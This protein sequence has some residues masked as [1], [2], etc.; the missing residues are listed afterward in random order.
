MTAT[1]RHDAMDSEEHFNIAKSHS[2]QKQEAVSPKRKSRTG[3]ADS[4]TKEKREA[5]KRVRSNKKVVSSPK[6]D[7]SPVAT[8]AVEEVFES[9]RR[10]KRS[11]V[12]S[13]KTK[14]EREELK[15]VRTSQEFTWSRNLGNADSKTK[16]KREAPKRVRSNKKVVISPKEDVSPVATT[17][18]E[19]VF[20][21]PRRKKRSGVTRSKSGPIT[22]SKSGPTRTNS[23]R[24]GGGEL[25][26]VPRSNSSASTSPL[27]AARHSCA[28]THAVSS[29]PTMAK[30]SRTPRRGSIANCDMS[31][32][33]T[34]PTSRTSS[35]KSFSSPIRTTPKTTPKSSVIPV[36]NSCSIDEDMQ[37]GDTW[38]DFERVQHHF[39][40]LEQPSPITD[41]MQTAFTDLKKSSTSTSAKNTATQLQRLFDAGNSSANSIDE[42]TVFTEVDFGSTPEVDFGSTTKLEKNPKDS[43]KKSRLLDITETVHLQSIEEQKQQQQ[44]EEEGSSNILGGK[45]RR[46]NKTAVRPRKTKVAEQV[47]KKQPTRNNMSEECKRKQV[48]NELVVTQSEQQQQK[49]ERARIHRQGMDELM[50]GGGGRKTSAPTRFQQKQVMSELVVTHSEQQQHKQERA[51]IHRQGMDESMTGGGGRKSSSPTRFQRKQVMSELVVTH[52]EQKLQKRERALIHRKGMDELMTGGD[53]RKTLAPTLPHRFQ[54]KRVMSELVVTQSEQ[55]QRKQERVRARNHRKGMDELMAGG[56][57]TQSEQQQRNQERARIH[58]KGMD[59]L[60][61]GGGGPTLPLRFQRKQVMSELVVTQSEQQQQKE[62]RARARNHRKG[63]DELMAG[64]GGKKALA[65]TREMDHKTAMRP[66]TPPR[67]RERLPSSPGKSSSRKLSAKQPMLTEK[68]AVTLQEDNHQPMLNENVAI[69]LQEDNCHT[70]E[71]GQD[72][73]TMRI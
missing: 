1:Q 29:F 22:R 35:T 32:S 11:G 8:T 16:E 18:A 56:G 63:M 5:P 65:P 47:K 64:D 27:K 40:F 42:E 52:S 41:D 10:K 7:V 25:S 6:E 20:E 60:M 46:R 72:W 19:E 51:R 70:H 4:K 2:Q 66:P 53:D 69:T 61:T 33:S 45:C 28:T 31:T 71:W 23:Q 39:F 17:A 37:T 62:E 43:L 58:R 59:E 57:G 3:K 9:P 55:Q 68:G 44:E 34:S 14:E 67:R 30:P 48:M 12:T 21:S 54:R 24:S 13:S 36:S 73:S 49:R 50:T 15:R 38:E 26:S